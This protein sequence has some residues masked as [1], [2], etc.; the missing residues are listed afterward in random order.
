MK[1]AGVVLAAG[2]SRR[3]GF[4]KAL[5]R[6]GADTFLDAMTQAL[7]LG[8]CDPVLAVVAEPLQPV[9]AGCRLLGVQLV[10]NPDPSRGQVSSLRCALEALPAAAGLIV[11]LVDQG[12]LHSGS[13][14]VVREAL[15]EAGATVVVACHQ[16]QR[17]HPLGFRREMFEALRSPAADGGARAVVEQAERAGRLRLLELD[18]PGVVRNLNTPEAYAAF[19][20][21]LP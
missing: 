11:V 3:M 15:G 16:G 14:A 4:P 20:A 8:G 17:G 5:L 2:A 6:A 12:T 21:S 19:R 13:V 10:I 9:R 1:P 18:D 7:W